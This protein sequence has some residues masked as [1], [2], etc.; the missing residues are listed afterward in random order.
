M[1]YPYGVIIPPD[2]MTK[3]ANAKTV[4]THRSCADGFLSFLLLKDALRN[5][6]SYRALAHD[7]EHEQLLATPGMVFCDMSP[8]AKRRSEFAA[9]DAVVLDHH[10]SAKDLFAAGPEGEPA[11]LGVYAD[12]PGVS[13]ATLALD[14]WSGCAAG[15]DYDYD[16]LWDLARLVGIYDTWQKSSPEWQAAREVTAALHHLRKAVDES[17]LDEVDQASFLDMLTNDRGL[18]GQTLVAAEDRAARATAARAHFLEIDTLRTRSLKVAFVDCGSDEINLAADHVEGADLVCSVRLVHGPE[19]SGSPGRRS[20]RYR[21]SMR[22]R[23]ETAQVELDLGQL[24]KVLG[25]GG[26]HD[27]AGFMLDDD[28]RSSPYA[29]ASQ[30]IWRGLVRLD[31]SRHGQA[32]VIDPGAFDAS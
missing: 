17:R 31:P 18:L 23:P 14:A 28:D 24:A 2:I 4:V 3:I 29:L 7:Q 1:I 20:L 32:R 12:A 25:G 22:R 9:V 6:C 16:E 13:G 8:P 15:W 27:A 30:A 11:L 19:V 5:Q 10:A 26:H 21:V